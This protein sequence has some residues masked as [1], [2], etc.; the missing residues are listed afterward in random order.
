MLMKTR[1]GEISCNF[2]NLLFSQVEEFVW[3]FFVERDGSIGLSAL[4]VQN[5]DQM[6]TA[7]TAVLKLSLNKSLILISVLRSFTVALQYGR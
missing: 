6:G 3:Q 7:K 2:L 1:V 5:F 4:V